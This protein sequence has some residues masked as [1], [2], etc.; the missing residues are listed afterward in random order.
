LRTAAYL[1][2]STAA[3]PLVYSFHRRR[4]HHRFGA[5]ELHRVDNG[6][7]FRVALWRF[8]P[9]SARFAHPVLLCP[10][11]GAN[12]FTYEPHPD[13][14]LA[15][16]LREAGFD[17]WV[18]ELRGHGASDRPTRG[19]PFGWSLDDHLRYDVT[20]AIEGVR[21]ISEAPGVHWVGHSMGGI[22]LYAH[23]SRAGGGEGLRSGVA[24]GS[25]L[26]YSGSG[27]WFDPLTRLRRVTE[28]LPSIP[29]GVIQTLAS[30]FGG[31][32]D[33]FNIQISNT[34]RRVWRKLQAIGWE[35]V[36]APVMR[37]L[38][39]AFEEGGLASI[40]GRLRYLAT[41]DQGDV[42]VLAIA[43]SVDRQCPPSAAQRTADALAHP[44]SRLAFFGKAHG[45][46]DEY[47]HFDLVMG[48][49]APREVWPVLTDW[50]VARD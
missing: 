22:L 1:A 2:A 21:R 7:G 37:Q 15:N 28:V 50:L 48:K 39:T 34:D 29:L 10:G 44:E 49:R 23:L 5:D 11:L 17:T 6:D 4:F 33:E 45:H 35:S 30:P 24:I 43:G 31:R 42:P 16:H 18:L 40:D 14:S 47:G 25:S 19:R 9:E 20:A 38:A 27:S 8:R 41:L 36:S 32:H 13:V 46:E 12:R 26:D 3:A